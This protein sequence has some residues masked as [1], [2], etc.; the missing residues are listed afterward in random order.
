MSGEHLYLGYILASGDEYSFDT[1]KINILS[2]KDK[3]QYVV[4]ELKQLVDIG[5]VNRDVFA[6]EGLKYEMIVF[7]E[8]Y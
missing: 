1:T 8:C 6:S 4:Y 2:L 7:E 3:E 5:V